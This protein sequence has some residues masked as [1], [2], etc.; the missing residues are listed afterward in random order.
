MGVTRGTT[1][2]PVTGTVTLSTPGMVYE[3]KQV[4]GNIVVTAPNVTIRNVKLI[5]RDNYY[6]ISV[7]NNNNWDATDAN[8]L[9]DH[10][11]I[12]LGGSTSVKGIAFNGYTARNVFFHNGADCAHWSTNV[13]I[14]DSLCAT[15]PDTNGDGWPDSTT[16]CG[17]TD[18]FDGFQSDGG[19]GVTLKHNTVRNPCAQTSDIL[20]SSNTSPIKNV[21]ITDNLL[22]GGGYSLYC[23]GSK[24]G[25]RV[26]N[27]VA[28]NNR[29][30]KTWYATGGS[31]GP[32]A[33][34]EYASVFSGN[35]WDDTG[36]S[37]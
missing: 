29:F 35:V 33:Y 31:W 1:L 14:Q 5:N 15:G 21:T 10:V 37:I 19:D 11:E 26:S 20:L 34:C 3:N 17:G 30:A 23:A 24:D 36:K 12:D 13:V 28:T 18:H 4:T 9:V 25:T 2:T 7:K 27:I 32:T 8:L 16:F 6:A 22:A